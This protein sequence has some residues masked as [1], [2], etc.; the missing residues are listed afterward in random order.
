MLYEQEPTQHDIPLCAQR[1]TIG[2]S[3][4][5][6]APGMPPLPIADLAGGALSTVARILAALLERERTG[7]GARIAALAF[8]VE[9]HA[10]HGSAN[11]GASGRGESARDGI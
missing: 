8:S 5:P 1:T 7:R 4:E 2:L 3:G 9:P 11:E 10:P 6:T